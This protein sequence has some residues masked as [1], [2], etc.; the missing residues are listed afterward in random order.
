MNTILCVLAAVL[1]IVVGTLLWITESRAYRIR[2]LA[3]YGWSQR[4]IAQHL[5]VTRY[6]VQKALR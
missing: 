5:N 2:R 6:Q 3:S 4:Q 1:A